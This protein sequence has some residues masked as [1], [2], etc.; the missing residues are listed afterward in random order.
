MK[1]KMSEKFIFQAAT[2]F[3]QRFLTRKIDNGAAFENGD[4][5]NEWSLTWLNP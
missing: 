4:N 1:R 5:Q 3:L 2:E